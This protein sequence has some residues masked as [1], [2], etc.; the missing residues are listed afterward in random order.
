M[1]RKTANYTVQDEGRDKG[2]IFVITEMSASQAESWAM[3]VLLALISGNVDIPEGVAELG[4]AGL[5]EL[6]LRSLSSLKWEVAEPLLAEMLSC[7][8]YIPSPDKTH[9]VRPLVESD[10]EEVV[11][12]LKLR[13][14][15]W[16]LHTDFLGAVAKSS[17]D[18]LKAAAAV[19]VGRVTRTSHK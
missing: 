14:E 7:V 6:G 3:R 5:A 16:N 17:K 13:M 1:P 19:S 15:V 9:M 10:I 12:R 2:K 18:H 11:T 4:M 8:Q